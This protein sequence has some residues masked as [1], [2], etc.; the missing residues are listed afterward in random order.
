M[1]GPI[2]AEEQIRVCACGVIVLVFSWGDDSDFLF[3]PDLIQRRWIRSMWPRALVESHGFGW[4]KGDRHLC[5]EP[6]HRPVDWVAKMNSPDPSPPGSAPPP[7]PKQGG[8]RLGGDGTYE[9]PTWEGG[10]S[11]S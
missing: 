8:M 7:G 2:I 3:D 11:C 4:H 5:C 9:G 6:G 10:P 1:L